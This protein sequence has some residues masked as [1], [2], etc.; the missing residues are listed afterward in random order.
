MT[1]S[2]P[3]TSIPH[4]FFSAQH[5]WDAL[6]AC[7]IDVYLGP[8]DEI[9]HD[10]GKNFDA[11][12]FRQYARALAINTHQVP[13]E[14]HQSVGI[15]ER[16]HAP[17]RRAYGI[18][19]S[20]MTSGKLIGKDMMLQMAIK[21]INDTAG[22]DGLVPT[23]LVFGAY[24]RM[25]EL[26]PPSPTIAQRATAIG[27]AMKDLR[28]QR[29]RRQLID[30]L[31]ERSGPDTSAVNQ[32][33]LGSEVLVYREKNGWLGPY[34]L[35]GVSANQTCKVDLP[36]AQQT[37]APRLS[38]HSC[39]RPCSS[40]RDSPLRHS[41]QVWSCAVPSNR[42]ARKRTESLPLRKGKPTSWLSSTL[43][44]PISPGNMCSKEHGEHISPPLVSLRP[45]S[46]CR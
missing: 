11:S 1:V 17:L 32:L 12:E 22:P 24:P 5:T 40:L 45:P 30:A 10:A 15:V 36:G 28:A 3:L 20:E 46:T 26:D 16:Y 37:F 25:S 42:T 29:A 6:R 8:P 23:L 31:R 27:L 39:V 19:K 21:A 13:V 41:Y 34:R 14:A 43:Q 9:V 4:V 38:S 7:W 2:L 35:L 18:V 44:T 33:P